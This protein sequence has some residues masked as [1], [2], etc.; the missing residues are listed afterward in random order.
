MGWNHFWRSLVIFYT[1]TAFSRDRFIYMLRSN[2]MRRPRK[3]QNSPNFIW[4]YL[5]SS[6]KL[7]IFFRTIVAF[8]EY[9]NFKNTV[10]FIYFCGLLRIYELYQKNISPHCGTR[11]RRLW[12]VCDYCSEFDFSRQRSKTMKTT[13]VISR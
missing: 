13:V 5:V 12:C 9:L 4:R 2:I 7:E 3:M 10:K 1:A 11:R 6:K 8:S